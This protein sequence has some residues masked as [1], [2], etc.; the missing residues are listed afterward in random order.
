MI[1]KMMMNLMLF[2]FICHTAFASDIDKAKMYY[3]NNLIIE[4]KRELIDIIFEKD[5]EKNKSEAYYLLGAIAFDENRMSDAFKIWKELVVK[6]PNSIRASE[7][8]DRIEKIAA[9]VGENKE[10]NVDNAI[11]QSYLNNAEFWSRNKGRSYSVDSSW[12]SSVEA[13]VKWYD[14][15]INEFPNSDASIIAYRDKIRTLIGWG[16]SSKYGEGVGAVGDLKKYMPQVEEAMAAFEKMHPDDSSLQA[17]RYQIAQTYW[18]KK[19]WA[20]TRKWLDI[21]VEKSGA[22]DSF[23]KDLAT[24]RL[25]KIEY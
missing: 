14:K 24:R 13:A 3:D 23:Y 2:L 15:V 17:L 22:E 5:S 18:H 9:I 25:N 19:K 6:Y 7:I 8:K 1:N 10:Q 16:G 21:I 20:E 11:A 4:A 12:I